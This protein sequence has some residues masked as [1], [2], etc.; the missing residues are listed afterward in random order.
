MLRFDFKNEKLNSIPGLVSIWVFLTGSRKYKKP[1]PQSSAGSQ[2]G[3][4]SLHTAMFRDS[5]DYNQDT[6]QIAYKD[7]LFL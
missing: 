6:L 3:L 5:A 4:H 2:K 7:V 1:F